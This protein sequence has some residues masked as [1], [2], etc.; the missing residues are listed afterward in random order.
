MKDWLNCRAQWP[1][2]AQMALKAWAYA[3]LAADRDGIA[4]DYTGR[5]DPD[6]ERALIAAWHLLRGDVEY[7]VG[8]EEEDESWPAT[9]KDWPARDLDG[10]VACAC[11]EWID[12]AFKQRVLERLT[13]LGGVLPGRGAEALY[14]KAYEWFAPAVLTHLAALAGVMEVDQDELDE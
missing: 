4:A 1:K 8:D 12:E 14:G 3:P 7:E 2:T 6:D 5:L 11:R 10:F 9:V 13:A